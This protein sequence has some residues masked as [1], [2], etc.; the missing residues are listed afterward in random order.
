MPNHILLVYTVY[1]DRKQNKL[2]ELYPLP[3]SSTQNNT[4][5]HRTHHGSISCGFIEP[6]HLS[7][8]ITPDLDSGTIWLVALFN[9]QGL[10]GLRIDLQPDGTM[11]FRIDIHEQDIADLSFPYDSMFA[12]T[13]RTRARGIART[14]SSPEKPMCA[15]YS[16]CLSNGDLM[17]KSHLVW[18]PQLLPIS[19]TFDGLYGLLCSAVDDQINILEFA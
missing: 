16:I 2:F 6:T 7:S 5:L 14:A 10:G 11:T 9:D 13:S 19:Y 18:I 3:N 17:I 12:V 1:I 8:N 15:M 4:T